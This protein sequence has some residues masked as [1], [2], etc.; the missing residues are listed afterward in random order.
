LLHCDSV[1]IGT[2]Q[3]LGVP[4]TRS[5]RPADTSFISLYDRSP[6]RGA[7]GSLAMS[8]DLPAAI[9]PDVLDLVHESVV[10]RDIDGRVLNWNK[11][12][13]E[14]YG[15]TAEQ[16]LGKD[17]QQLLN[18]R[19]FPSTA[20]AEAKLLAENRWRGR[21]MRTT[22]SGAELVVDVHWTLRRNA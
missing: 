20:T 19:Q 3:L 15:W 9:T 13:A 1:A 17:A 16:A 2:R 14:L 22:A 5:I 6:G 12:A 21:L 7:P 4:G 18:T 10:L 11:A 8:I